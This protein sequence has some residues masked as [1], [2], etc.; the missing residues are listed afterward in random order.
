[1]CNIAKLKQDYRVAKKTRVRVRLELG[2][3]RYGDD[4]VFVIL[5]IPSN[6]GHN[7]SCM[8]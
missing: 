2:K 4:Y 8:I 7:I 5:K 3:V 6:A 1:M